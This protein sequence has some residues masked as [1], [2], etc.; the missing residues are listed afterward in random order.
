MSSKKRERTP[1]EEEEEATGYQKRTPMDL[2]RM[3]L[4]KL[5]S[6]PEKEINIQ[7]IRE[8]KLPKL[9][10][11]DFHT[12]GCESWPFYYYQKCFFFF[13]LFWI[14]ADFPDVCRTASQ[15]N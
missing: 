15:D 3:K 1:E 6:H 9:K 7:P 10:E 11:F 13:S 2:Q 8:L 12:Q 4:E 5:M 14:L